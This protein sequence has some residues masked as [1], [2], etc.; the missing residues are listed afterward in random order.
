MT[1]RRTSPSESLFALA[2]ILFSFAN[3]GATIVGNQHRS[4]V[5]KLRAEN[6]R[7][8]NQVEAQRVGQAHNN[9]ILGD[10]NVELRLLQIEEK[11]RKLGLNAAPFKAAD[12]DD[13]PSRYELDK[14]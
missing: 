2:N 4:Q 10:L 1:T 3:I 12:Y 13:P 9:V 6:L 8:K 5:D 14:G 7:L 11:K